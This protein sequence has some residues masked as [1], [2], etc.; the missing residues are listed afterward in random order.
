MQTIPE[1]IIPYV[2]DWGIFSLSEVNNC[3]V[4]FNYQ[5]SYLAFFFN[6]KVKKQHQPTKFSPIPTLGNGL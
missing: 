6:A 5:F 2:L 4:E 3:S 1:G